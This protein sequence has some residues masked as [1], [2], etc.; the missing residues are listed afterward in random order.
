MRFRLVEAVCI[1][2]RLILFNEACGLDFRYWVGM[3]ANRQD[4]GDVGVILE[5]KR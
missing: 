5:N 2:L 4:T 1:V 3:Y